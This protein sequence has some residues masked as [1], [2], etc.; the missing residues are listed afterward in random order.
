MIDAY[1]NVDRNNQVSQWPCTVGLLA[2][3]LAVSVQ[4]ARTT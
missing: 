3:L 4:M 1:L 2:D